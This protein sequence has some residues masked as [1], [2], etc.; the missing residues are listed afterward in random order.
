[1]IHQTAELSRVHAHTEYIMQPRHALL[2]GIIWLLFVRVI[3][4]LADI[5]KPFIT[6]LYATLLSFK[7]LKSK[8][9]RTETI[10]FYCGYS[11]WNSECQLLE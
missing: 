10:F 1:M 3:K 7:L 9:S 11:I 4:I 5:F 2:I 6:L 8:F